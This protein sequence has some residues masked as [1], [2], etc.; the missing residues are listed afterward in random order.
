MAL[1][2]AVGAGGSQRQVVGVE[3]DPVA[4]VADAVR[5]DLEALGRPAMHRSPE[6]RHFNL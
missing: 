3:A 4:A 5:V 2:R 1:R 6:H